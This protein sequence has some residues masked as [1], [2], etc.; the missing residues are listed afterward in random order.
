MSADKYRSIFLHQ[1]KA[2]AYMLNFVFSVLVWNQ[3]ATEADAGE[4]FQKQMT[5]ISFNDIPPHEPPLQASS[6]PIPRI[7]IWPIKL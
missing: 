5:L 1:T 3:P 7:R 2:I 4:S 6:S